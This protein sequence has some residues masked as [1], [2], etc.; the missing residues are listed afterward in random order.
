MIVPTACRP[1]Q[2]F[3]GDASHSAVS[4]STVDLISKQLN[5]KKQPYNFAIV[6]TGSVYGVEKTNMFNPVHGV[7]VH[8]KFFDDA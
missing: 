5:A 6:N 4:G 7:H 1:H 3:L 8:G 2:R